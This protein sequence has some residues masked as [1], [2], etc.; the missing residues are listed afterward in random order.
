MLSMAAHAGVCCML[1]VLQHIPPSK[2]GDEA[3]G[4]GHSAAVLCV[5]AHPTLPLLVMNLTVL[6]SCGQPAH[7]TAEGG[8]VAS[9]TVQC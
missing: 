6:S 8:G 3:S 9:L 1:Q 5:A 2:V 4:P 7:L